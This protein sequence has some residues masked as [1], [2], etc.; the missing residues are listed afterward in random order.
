MVAGTL[1]GSGKGKRLKIAAG[2]FYDWLGEP[3]PVVP[4]LGIDFDVRPDDRADRVA[5]ARRDHEFIQKLLDRGACNLDLPL[6]MESP[7]NME[8]TE[9]GFG[10]ELARI[11]AVRVRSAVQENWREL[12]AIEEQVESMTEDFGGEDPLHERV[13][14][15]F[16]EAKSMLV[17]LHKRVPKYTGPFDLPDP[18][19]ELRA[20]VQQIV[21]NEVKHLRTR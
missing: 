11:L 13:R 9:K 18:D 8:P 7:L 16:D 15:N 6:D 4:D 5:R 3:V 10:V 21:D 17:D 12:R 20:M 1:S 14:A 19:D 2:S